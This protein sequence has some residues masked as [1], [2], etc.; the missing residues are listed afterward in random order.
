MGKS[1]II[2]DAI[3]ENLTAVVN[4]S[5]EN[6]GDTT[7]LGQFSLW[8]QNIH[9][10]VS[11]LVCV[12]GII[13][14]IMNIVVLTQ[15]NMVS[16]TNYLLT[17]L[18]IADMLTMLSYVPYAFYFY[19]LSTPDETRK[20]PLGWIIYLLF[21]TNFTITSH[22]IAMYLT[23]ALAVFRYIVVCH[24]VH[25]PR[26]CN[27]Q[28]ARLTITLVFLTTIIFCIP[29]YILYTP[30]QLET[31]GYWFIQHRFVTDLHHDF[32]NWL[33]G[34]V[35]K[36]APCVLLTVLSTLLIRAMRI[37]AEKRRKLKS[38]SCRDD[39]ERN[40]EHNRT[41]VMLVAIVVCFVITEL[42][43]GIL[44][45]LG[46]IHRA[47]FDDIYVPLG[48]VWDIFVLVNS[49]V[50]FILYC[51]MSRQFRGTFCTVFCSWHSKSKQLNGVYKCA[52]TMTTGTQL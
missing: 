49:S 45:F 5:G 21:H 50:N 23:V 38:P 36:V 13:A 46:G 15:K 37:A 26:L 4:S 35:L 43:Q 19:C 14:N 16:P 27:L 2:Y 9:G 24:H 34:V 17:A 32:N 28:R 52:N 31:G 8:Y 44:S 40:S 33:F 30:Q 22:T 39:S 42:P 11:I 7:A 6:V 10:Y 29:N 48:D 1:D 47:I 25:G 51:I 41:T 3:M 12:F 18:A 20:H